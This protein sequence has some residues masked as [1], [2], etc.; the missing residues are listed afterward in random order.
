MQNPEVVFPAP[1]M[2]NILLEVFSEFGC[3]ETVMRTIEV[4]ASPIAMFDYNALCPDEEIQFI[5]LSQPA[6][7]TTLTE[8][9]W[10][11]GG[12][13]SPEQNPTATFGPGLY[14]ITL[15]VSGS[16]QCIAS[17]QQEIEVGM[18][19]DVQFSVEQP[20]IENASLLVDR[21]QWGGENIVS[22]EWQVD[23][24]IVG[25]DSLTTYSFA[26][27]GTY[28]VALEVTT[29]NGCTYNNEDV[30]AIQ[31]P[32]EASF[33]VTPGSGS[34][35]LEVVLENTTPGSTAQ[36][37]FVNG[38]FIGDQSRQTYVFT[39]DGVYD[40]SLEAID[41]A[42]CSGTA[43][44]QIRVGT[45]EMD[46]AANTL[47]VDGLDVLI[48]VRNLGN[49]QVNSI[50]V[51]LLSSD[52]QIP[53][54]IDAALPPGQSEVI[55]IANEYP[56]DGDICATIE[57][58]IE[59]FPDVDLANN[60]A[61]ILMDGKLSLSEPY[62]NPA[63]DVVNINIAAPAPD[64]L[65]FQWVSADGKQIEVPAVNISNGLG[66]YS[67]DTAVLARGVYYLKVVTDRETEIFRIVIE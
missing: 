67:F 8:W 32:P 42:G 3:S 5:D 53:M 31:T 64:V 30:I 27:T 1:G 47:R 21:T 38:M 13:F 40:L 34:A 36:S 37:W 17:T 10:D 20:C 41:P 66:R 50:P 55:R 62:P 44:R 61:C 7:G 56:G 2:Y 14:T 18:P 19:L 23:G 12:S 48:E 59:G 65:E 52:G 11:L 33:T 57:G 29:A 63:R 60:S 45:A 46:L 9:A 54:M 16:N 39:Q 15:T 58:V 28:L 51:L 6:S 35:P 4:L 24:E 22:R 25:S 43:M 26:S 49:V